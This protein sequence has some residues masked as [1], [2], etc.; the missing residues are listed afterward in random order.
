MTDTT[1]AQART[2]KDIQGIPW[3]R[4]NITREDYRRTR[5]EQ[6]RNYENVPLSGDE[7]DKVQSCFS[8]IYKSDYFFHFW[9]HSNLFMCAD[10][11]TKTKGW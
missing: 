1:A 10:M 4:L 6:Y 3:K 5:L 2:G 9:F 7:V 11:Q 8:Y